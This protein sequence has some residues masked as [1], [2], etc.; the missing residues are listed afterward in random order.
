MGQD[1]SLGVELQEN[2]WNLIHFD[3]IMVWCAI[4]LQTQKREC[5]S[6]SQSILAEEWKLHSSSSTTIPKSD[7]RAALWIFLPVVCAG[8][9]PTVLANRDLVLKRGHLCGSSKWVI[10]ETELFFFLLLAD[11]LSRFSPFKWCSTTSNHFR[12]SRENVAFV[13]CFHFYPVL[14]RSGCNSSCSW[15]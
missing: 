11:A 15:L 5:L 6:C 9:V 12:D 1:S 8:L 10:L 4:A 14:R 13:K 2:D 7:K 3:N